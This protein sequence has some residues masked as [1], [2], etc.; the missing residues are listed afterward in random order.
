MR[1]FQSESIEAIAAALEGYNQTFYV[2]DYLDY[3]ILSAPLYLHHEG[4]STIWLRFIAFPDGKVTAFVK[5]VFRYRVPKERLDRANSLCSYFNSSPRFMTY[6][7]D[8]DGN[9]NM[10]YCP[11]QIA[12]CEMGELA[13]DV[14]LD[15]KKHLE[16][17]YVLLD[18]AI[19]TDEEL[20]FIPDQESLTIKKLDAF[21]KGKV[22]EDRDR[23]DDIEDYNERRRTLLKEREQELTETDEEYHCQFCKKG[24]P[25]REYRFCPRCGKSV[26]DEA[27]QV[28]SFNNIGK[29]AEWHPGYTDE[30]GMT[31][32]C[33]RCRHFRED[34]SIEDDFNYCEECGAAMVNA[35]LFELQRKTLSDFIDENFY[36]SN[37]YEIL[38]DYLEQMPYSRESVDELLDAASSWDIS[39]VYC[40]LFQY[41]EFLRPDELAKLMNKFQTTFDFDFLDEYELEAYETVAL[42][43][44]TEAL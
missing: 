10:M 17:E 32:T 29:N 38:Y 12:P 35:E 24:I 4:A 1:H 39:E 25:F 20:L 26:S 6:H 23:E 43:K 31:L 2:H 15:A 13:P 41:H 27:V 44:E 34:M 22:S 33:S 37:Y 9:L 21:A 18:R 36:D 30:G 8:E 14:F 28:D 11:P 5:N 19:M 40:K 16:S 7:I 42:P 3:E